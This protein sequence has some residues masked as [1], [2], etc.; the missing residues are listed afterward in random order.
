MDAKKI[1]SAAY[2]S[3]PLPT[4]ATGDDRILYH[5]MWLVYEFNKRGIY[6]KEEAQRMKESLENCWKAKVW[7]RYVD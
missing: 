4:D 6:S 3:R 2:Y 5:A 7:D 1:Y